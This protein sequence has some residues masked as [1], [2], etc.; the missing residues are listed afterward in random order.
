MFM[1]RQMLTPQVGYY[2]FIDPEL[3]ECSFA[4]D[5][6]PSGAGGAAVR[7]F[8]CGTLLPQLARITR[9]EP[10]NENGFTL[11]AGK[12]RL[13]RTS[14]KVDRLELLTF[15]WPNPFNKVE[16]RRLDAPNLR[17]P[18]RQAVGWW[19]FSAGAPRFDDTRLLLMLNGTI[20]ELRRCPKNSP[21][22]NYASGRWR[23]DEEA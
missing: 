2:G 11:F 16:I 21:L 5:P 12:T 14:D 15:Y 1:T 7:T 17:R 22:F 10:D 20:G 6:S 13:A 3:E 23:A 19:T 4:L 9:W 18:A 8:K